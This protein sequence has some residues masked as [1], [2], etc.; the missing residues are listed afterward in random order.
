MAPAGRKLESIHNK[1]IVLDAI[2]TESIQPL[3]EIT[4]IEE[5]RLPNQIEYLKLIQREGIYSKILIIFIAS[6]R[7]IKQCLYVVL[8][9][10]AEVLIFLH[11][12]LA[13]IVVE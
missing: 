13:V 10:E 4:L 5:M 12:M 3:N 2:G 7:D 1:D 9:L 11:E 8:C 6:S